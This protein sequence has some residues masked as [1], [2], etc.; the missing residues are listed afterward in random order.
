MD[1]PEK[2]VTQDTQDEGKQIKNKPQHVLDITTRKQTKN[3]VNK[4]LGSLKQPEAKTNRTPG[5]LKQPEAKTNRTPSLY[6]K[7]NGHHNTE[8]TIKII[9]PPV[10]IFV[11]REHHIPRTESNFSRKQQTQT[12]N[13]SIQAQ[14]AQHT[15]DGDVVKCLNT[16][17][18]LERG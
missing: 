12:Q 9:D 17:C 2:L 1:N 3:N 5:S 13:N 11:L 18:K 14:L 4:T 7:R 15:V 6:G 16:N 10:H 8:P